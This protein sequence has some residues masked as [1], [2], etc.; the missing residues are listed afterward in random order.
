MK[1]LLQNI[2][3]I[4]ILKFQENFPYTKLF[5]QKRLQNVGQNTE[6]ITYIQVVHGRQSR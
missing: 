5:M 4:L 1:L 6:I 3:K 2:G